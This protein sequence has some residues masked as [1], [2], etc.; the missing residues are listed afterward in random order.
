[1]KWLY[2]AIGGAAGTVFRY[3]LQ[4]WVER[5]APGNFPYGTLSVNVL[6]CLLLGFLAGFF[7]GPQLV[8]EELRIGLSI[9]LLGGLTTFSTFGLETF[10]LATAGQFRLALLNMLVSCAL[11]FAAVWLGY[12]LAER[13]YGV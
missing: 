4:G 11:G 13:L 5:F 6:G 3:A 12:R 7:A 8:R 10:N 1:M 2:L 9:G